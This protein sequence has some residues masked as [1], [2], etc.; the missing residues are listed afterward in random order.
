[1]ML[2]LSQAQIQAKRSLELFQKQMEN[3]RVHVKQM[4]LGL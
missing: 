2:L 1:M 4:E 3:E